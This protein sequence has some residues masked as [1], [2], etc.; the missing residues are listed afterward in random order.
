MATTLSARIPA[1][2]LGTSQE[3]F[4]PLESATQ[5]ATCITSTSAVTTAN[6]IGGY[7]VPAG[8]T[9]QCLFRQCAAGSV[10]KLMP[11]IGHATT[12]AAK[13]ATLYLVLVHE[14]KP[15]NPSLAVTYMRSYVGSL[16]LTG[17]ASGGNLT[18]THLKQLADTLATGVGGF[19]T[20]VGCDIVATSAVPGSGIEVAGTGLTPNYQFATLDLYG[21]AFLEVWGVNGAASQ[22]VALF[23]AQC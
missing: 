3:P 13:T 6:L 5:T 17:A 14:I 7:G 21:A 9:G 8:T 15:R 1:M 22:G 10:V 4:A 11:L 20:W 16:A 2:A 18:A 19:A 12:P 23:A